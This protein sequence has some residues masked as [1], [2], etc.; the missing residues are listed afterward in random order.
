MRRPPG[1]AGSNGPSV[2]RCLRIGIERHPGGRAEP[3]AAAILAK[4]CRRSTGRRGAG[5]KAGVR[6]LQ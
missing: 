2:R 1:L 5:S 4:G 3:L 6:K